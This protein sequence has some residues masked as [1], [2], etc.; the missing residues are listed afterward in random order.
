MLIPSGPK[1]KST[2][3]SAAHEL[4][5]ALIDSDASHRVGLGT[6]GAMR[7][8]AAIDHNK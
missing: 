1:D 6:I 4:L 3:T 2:A 8:G 7:K 5:S